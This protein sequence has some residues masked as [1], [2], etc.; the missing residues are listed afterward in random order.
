MCYQC[1][2]RAR[3]W[4]VS[5]PRKLTGGCMTNDAPQCTLVLQ[6]PSWFLSGS[7]R[8]T[9]V[10]QYKKHMG[11]KKSRR[12][13]TTSNEGQAL[14]GS[15][16]AEASG[17][18]HAGRRMKSTGALASGWRRKI[19]RNPGQS[20]KRWTKLVG[21]IFTATASS[22]TILQT[23]TPRQSRYCKPSKTQYPA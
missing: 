11:S 10:T 19:G 1:L 22:Q 4:L 5:D 9:D 6:L 15:Q 17:C 16:S 7:F 20:C 12:N 23:R 18:P 21:S 2:S 13:S 8:R 14:I 3:I